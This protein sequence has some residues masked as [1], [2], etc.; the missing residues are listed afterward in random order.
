MSDT[1][2]RV[3]L[4]GATG[5]IGRA[6]IEQAKTRGDM[7][8][9]ALARR[10]MALPPGARLEMLIAPPADWGDA[11]AR[12]R[13]DAV[14]CALGT[15]WNKA[16]RDRDAFRAVDHDLVLQVAE[17]AKEA[18][19]R[20]FIAVS[21]VGANTGSKAFYLRVK[22]EV[23]RD[24]AKLRFHRLD[25]LRPGLLRG[26][27]GS[28]RRLGERI[29]IVMAPLTDLFLQGDKRKYRSIA[30]ATVAQA[31]IGLLSEKAQ[32]RFVHENPMILRAARRVDG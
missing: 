24:L 22:G 11:I 4:V 32:G 14:I 12:M 23:E 31:A 17:A 18:G 2:Q 16:G 8:L 6:V 15:T 10:E 21:S 1:S 26:E 20:Q 28:D 25:L 30:A 5:L 27:R 19:S 9:V 13:P 7:R 29:G 3:L